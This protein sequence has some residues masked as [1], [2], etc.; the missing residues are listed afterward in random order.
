[1][2]TPFLK[3]IKLSKINVPV[4]LKIE[5]IEATI[6]NLI[7]GVLYENTNL[8][9]DDDDDLKIRAEKAENISISFDSSHINYRVP[10]KLWV[11]KIIPIT[12]VEVEVE[13][14]IALSL[15]TEY[16]IEKNWKLTTST[17]IIEYEW[18]Q[19]PQLKIG[20]FNL[21]IKFIINTILDRGK[22]LICTTLDK[23]LAKNFDLR[24]TVNEAWKTIQSPILIAEE[25][26]LWLNILPV[27]VG[28]APLISDGRI[29][30]SI[31]TVHTYAEVEIGEKPIV[32]KED[33]LPPFQFSAEIEDGFDVH[34]KSE[35]T[36][37]EAQ[38]IARKYVIGL[39]F[40]KSIFN[41]K[42]ED[43]KLYGKG[44]KI[45][46]ETKL[47]GSYRGEVFFEGK[48]VFDPEKNEIEIQ[49]P[50]YKLITKNILI[51]IINWLFGWA[52]K[53]ILKK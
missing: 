18:L 2:L 25:F 40:S 19:K 44:E 9:D 47:T 30:K 1:M 45:A 38:K 51:R 53:K 14:V 23:E 48:P 12:L 34:L 50:E 7:D 16:K 32:E 46:V 8:A 5:E 27:K 24:K 17:N 26:D 11:K 20:L 37:S 41:I 15:S 3:E 13:G 22:K 52:I 49:N 33:P 21:P 42:I 4:T 43:L 29:L 35:I 6:N 10:L 31:V 39:V 36:Y 28:M